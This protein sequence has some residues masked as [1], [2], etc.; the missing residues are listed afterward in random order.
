MFKK[1]END[2]KFFILETSQPSDENII[3]A[4]KK[5]IKKSCVKV[6]K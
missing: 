6:Y 1:L 5:Y 2:G 4:I 3:K